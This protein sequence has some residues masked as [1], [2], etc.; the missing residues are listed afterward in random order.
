MVSTVHRAKGLEFDRV[1]IVPA[2]DRADADLDP[3]EEMRVSYVALSRARDEVYLGSAPA[4]AGL[5]F[6]PRGVDRWAQHAWQG[7]RP[8]RVVSLEALSVDVDV[9]KPT[10]GHSGTAVE[11][12]A[13][14]RE[15]AVTGAALV[16][17][18]EPDGELAAPRFTLH[19]S[20]DGS[21]V[22]RTSESFGR[23]L[24]RVL[25]PGYGKDWPRALLGLAVGSV[26]TVAG[27]PDLTRFA[28]LPGS[29]LWLV[30]R[31]TGLARPDWKNEWRAGPDGLDREVR[32]P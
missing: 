21:I 32:I 5:V 29:G 17:V 6:K 1:V 9:Q 30:P 11:V 18:L 26:E 25:R 15:R 22:G 10:R 7:R 24:A 4:E 16:G 3:A 13:R 28:G 20:D 23:A 2:R 19:L 8:P 27:D 14:L 31:L 12:Q